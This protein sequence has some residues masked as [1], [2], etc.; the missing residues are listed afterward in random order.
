MAT[1]LSRASHYNDVI[2]GAIASQSPASRVFT[3]PF[4]QTQIKETSKLRVTGLCAGNSPGTGEFPA[5]R[6]SNAENVSIWWRHHDI[7][8]RKGPFWI[9]NC[10]SVGN[11]S[12]C[13]RASS[14]VNWNFVN[15]LPTFTVD[16]LWTVT[17]VT[18]HTTW[19]TPK[20]PKID[21]SIS[22]LK[23]LWTRWFEY[24]QF[25]EAILIAIRRPNKSQLVEMRCYWWLKNR[26][27][28]RNVRY[29]HADV[30]RNVKYREP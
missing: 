13:M 19:R 18:L 30:N 3:Q 12:M 8:N 27:V 7:P 26:R 24:T 9:S 21:Q 17:Y 14:G 2:M 5:Q 1:I 15:R 25:N 23:R 11:A 16:S 29:L 22:P 10:Q 20:E 28:H 4:I 6:A